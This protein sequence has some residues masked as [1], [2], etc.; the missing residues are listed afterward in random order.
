MKSLKTTLNKL[1]L[2]VWRQTQETPSALLVLG[3]APLSPQASSLL[4]AVLKAI[5]LTRRTVTVFVYDT[6]HADKTVARLIQQ[7]DYRCVI[8]FRG[9]D[10]VAFDDKT[11]GATTASE[12]MS[13]D[14]VIATT[15]TAVSY[16]RCPTLTELLQSPS[17]KRLAWQSLRALA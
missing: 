2:P 4:D 14:D 10:S 11:L 7:S 9:L 12:T 15:K 8:D 1:G 13:S 17:Q 3:T 6:V 16:Y 5:G